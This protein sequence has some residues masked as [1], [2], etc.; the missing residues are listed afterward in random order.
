M[1]APVVW[2]V[3]RV[4]AWL[5]RPLLA[6]RYR[7]AI[8]GLEAIRTAG[9]HGILFL[10]N[11]SAL[12]DPA[13]LMAWLHPSFEPRP[14]ADE[15]QV[16]R[17]VFGS[18]ALLYGSRILPNL[19][20]R[21]AEAAARTRA[22]LTDIADGLRAGENI[23]LYPSG[24]LKRGYLEEL[25]SVSGV[26]TLVKAVPGVRLV[27][28]RINGLWGSSFSIGHTGEMP[29]LG[30]AVWGGLK[31]IV[32][33]GVFFVPK[34]SVTIEF[35]EPED[36]PRTGS[37]AEINRYLEAFYNVNATRNLYVPY[38]VWE[39]GGSRER[40]DPP[41]VTRSADATRVPAATRDLVLSHLRD[42]SGRPDLD[43]SQHL[44]R[45]LGLDSLA[46]A[47]LVAWIQAEFGFSV[48]TPESLQTVAD[49]VL[50]AGGQ[51]VS[52]KSDDLKPI[53]ASWFPEPS[54]TRL[55]EVSDGST[56]AEVFLA[57][58]RKRPNQV[59][60]AD[61]T[62]GVRT[63][64]D[65]L[66]AILVLKPVI[67]AMP[68]PYV[69]IMLPASVASAVFVLA[70]MFAGKTAVMV[71]W[72]TGARTVR[73][74]LDLLGVRS[75]ITAKALTAK[76][77]TMGVE[78]GELEDRFVH[79]E[80]LGAAVPAGAKLRAAFRARL[81]WTGLEAVTP[82][83]VAVV[84]F[85]SGS[86]HLPKAVPLTHTNLLAN[87]RDIIPVGRLVERDAILGM[88]PPFHSFGL[89]ATVM[90][91]CCAGLRTVFHANPTESALLARLVEA[92]RPTVIFGTPTFLAGIARVADT[93][94]LASLRV[95]VTGAEK[96]PE[97]LYETLRVRWPGLVVL[98]GYG[99]TEC[100]PVV[101]V[102]TLDDPVP[103]SIGRF[104]SS[105][106]GVVVDLDEQRRVP[107]GETGML[108]VRGPSIFGGYLNSTGASPFVEFDGRSWYRTGD[109]VSVRPDGV[110]FFKGRLKRFVKLGGEMVSLPAIEAVLLGH[111]GDADQGPVIAVEAVGDGDNPDIALFSTVPAERAHVNALIR[112]AGLSPL[113]FVRQVVTV[114]AIPVLGSGK[115]DY[116]A[117]RAKLGS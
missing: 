10:P 92:Y 25:G 39:G 46:A 9:R 91:P 14:L 108:L 62:S 80:E 41:V 58:A 18:I 23:L 55:V 73:Q 32:L 61:Q 69:G 99:I 114:D 19:E 2:F 70:A 113:H 22:A 95:A 34:R 52:T 29:S 60:F 27:L 33:S 103:G 89:T 75:V 8:R 67:E 13:I 26:E 56:L 15:H 79:A 88:L 82:A 5:A 86:E 85:T 7:V 44:S 111:F 38:R 6:L 117:L 42:A 72:T 4:V 53:P 12:I 87:V 48:D 102:N 83:Q 45:D 49:V 112:D 100:S 101:S 31:A 110:I 40:P 107:P 21:G 74:S 97:T 3:T 16:R 68:G 93:R 43:T 36:I 51:G 84:L 98:E 104:F 96:C 20:R 115:T 30:T 106:E 90:L 24:R 1:R 109:L 59:I 94:Q 64:R 17:S 71:N 57:Q 28:V 116:R 47:E 76:L 105:V 50:A 78:L 65:L 35:A 77:A 63:Y 11:H 81:G 54:D 66:T 37:R